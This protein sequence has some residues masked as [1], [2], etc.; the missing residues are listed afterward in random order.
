MRGVL[1]LAGRPCD[2]ELLGLALSYAFTAIHEG[3]QR[4]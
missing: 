1:V 4:L 3:A 2:S